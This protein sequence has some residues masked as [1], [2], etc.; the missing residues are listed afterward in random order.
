MAA[1]RAD[2]VGPAQQAFCK[3]LRQVELAGAAE[4]RQALQP[5]LDS[6]RAWIR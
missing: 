5:F 2:E 4:H 1:V 6:F 3:S